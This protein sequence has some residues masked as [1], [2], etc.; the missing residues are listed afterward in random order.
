MGDLSKLATST[1][2][3][4]EGVL[5]EYALGIRLRI[6]RKPNPRYDA[7][8]LE[9][10]RTVQVQLQTGVITSEAAAKEI[11][12]I[13]LEATGRFVLVGW[14]ELELG[15]EVVPYSAE[16]A[17]ELL[18]DPAYHDLLDFVHTFSSRAA[19]YRRWRLEEAVGNS[20]GPS[21]GG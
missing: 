9:R 16:K 12:R 14:E 7:F 21:P 18:S 2:H 19:N 3:E 6:A 8:R 5:T 10:L 1:R 4:V 15:G 13:D 20:P 17:I 11:E